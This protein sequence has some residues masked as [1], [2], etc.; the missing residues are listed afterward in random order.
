[1]TSYPKGMIDVSTILAYGF[2]NL[3]YFLYQMRRFLQRSKAGRDIKAM[4][5]YLKSLGQNPSKLYSFLQV[6]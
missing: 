6:V 1:M 4:Y 2:V 5:R 3:L